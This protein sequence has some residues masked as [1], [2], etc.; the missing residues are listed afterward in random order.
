MVNG[1][2]SRINLS[3]SPF[4]KDLSNGTTF[5]WSFSLASTVLL[6]F[7][8]PVRI[9]GIYFIIHQEPEPESWEKITVVLSCF[10][11]FQ[12]S[13]DRALSTASSQA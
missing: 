13:L 6:M 4:N 11:S 12:P 2:N 1:Q 3:A 10:S 8:V 9:H 5:S 7:S